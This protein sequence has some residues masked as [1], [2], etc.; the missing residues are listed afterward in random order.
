MIRRPPRST[1]F[2]YTTLF[3]SHYARERVRRLGRGRIVRDEGN[4]LERD[5][6]DVPHGLA[7]Q[8]TRGAERTGLPVHRRVRVRDDGLAPTAVLGGGHRSAQGRCRGGL[9]HKR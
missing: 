7:A 8:D 6:L 5:R 2:P 9:T 4:A 1:L 3:R